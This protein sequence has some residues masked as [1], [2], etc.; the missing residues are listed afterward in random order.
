MKRLSG[1]VYIITG[2][3]GGL[4]RAIALS[5]AQEGANLVLSD[6][7]AAPLEEL[8]GQ[9]AQ[10]DVQTAVLAGDACDVTLGAR[11]A[12]LAVSRLGRLDGCVP[13]AG[14][15]RCRPLAEIDAEQWDAVMAVNLRSVFFTLQ[16]VSR[17]IS[18]GG[19]IVTVSST[20]ADGPRPNN[21]DY[22][23]SKAG[24]NHLTRTF[25]LE[26]APRRVRVNAVSPGIIE[27]AMWRQVDAERGGMQGLS[28][29]QL[30]QRMVEKIP[31]GRLGRGE[32]VASVVTF[33]LSE[34]SAYVTGQIITID[35]GF[36][37]TT[38]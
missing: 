25:A 10:L 9:L 26:L 6:V 13:C 7:D 17:H 31:L 35:G 22:G 3:G 5:A 24:V 8:A 14:I 18:D 30:S 11:L 29:G 23:V 33:L 37:L 36:K 2:A 16:A 4:G 21:P 12:E 34:E 28:P 1:K 19:S 32:D 27:T 38:T 15:I 20:S